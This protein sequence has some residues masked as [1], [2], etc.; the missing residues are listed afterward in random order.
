MREQKS[1]SVRSANNSFDYSLRAFK[2]LLHSLRNPLGVALA[3]A[4]DAQSNL[5]LSASDYDDA[6]NA[7]GRIRDHL[8]EL[9]PILTLDQPHYVSLSLNEL[10]QLCELEGFKLDC[11]LQKESFFVVEASLV[12]VWLQCFNKSIS[13]GKKV[14]LELLN[15]KTVFSLKFREDFRTNPSKTFLSLLSAA[16]DAWGANLEILEGESRLRFGS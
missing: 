9:Q 15:D 16:C 14:T 11:L 8:D 4:K 7:L 5:V 13:E 2:E 12:E 6:V 10:A 3:V 1:Y